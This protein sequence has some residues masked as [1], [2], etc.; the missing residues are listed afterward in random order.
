MPEELPEA[1]Q[2]ASAVVGKICNS[3]SC[4]NIPQS[5]SNFKIQIKGSNKGQLTN[6]CIKCMEQDAGRKR[7]SRE[8][9]KEERAQTLKT[10]W[11]DMRPDSFFETLKDSQE[12]DIQIQVS[13]DTSELIP[14][15]L[16]SKER[17]DGLS[18]MIND[19]MDLNWSPR[20]HHT[21]QAHTEYIY[22]WT[23]ANENKKQDGK[24][25]KQNEQKRDRRKMERGECGGSMR[26]IVVDGSPQMRVSVRHVHS[27]ASYEDIRLPEA[28][29]EF[30]RNNLTLTPAKLWQHIISTEGLK[31]LSQLVQE[32]WRLSDDPF[33]SAQQ[34]LRTEGEAAFAEEMSDVISLPGT[35]QLAFHIKDIVSKWA[36]FTQELA[37]D[38]TW[39]TNRQ[40]FELFAA[41]ADR[42]YGIGAP[43]AYLFIQTSKQAAPGSK[44]A[45]I[46]SWLESLKRLGI[47]PEF[48]LT[49][50]DQSEINA[51]KRVWPDAKHQ[52]CFWRAL[53]AVK[54]RLAKN[55]SMPAHYN[56]ESAHA[57]FNFID[58]LFILQAQQKPGVPKMDKPPEKPLL[59]IQ[60]IFNNC[61]RLLTQSKF[62]QCQAADVESEG[63]DD[64]TYWAQQEK[65]PDQDR[66]GLRSVRADIVEAH[67]DGD[68][69]SEEEEWEEEES[70]GSDL[71]DGD[72]VRC[73]INKIINETSSN[74]IED[75]D[76][77]EE[78]NGKSKDSQY[79]F[80]P[81][82]HRLPL[83]C[84][85]AKH[86]SLHP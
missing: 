77:P 49:D 9:E 81:S 30:I 40:N 57:V 61:P 85:F 84:L 35:R 59:H 28:W 5:L 69:D 19:V 66:P 12:S 24:Q 33:E 83:L 53:R 15:D 31:D 20:V 13:V 34:Y 42:P 11:P 44:E 56:G 73:L 50:K 39:N 58:P 52:L 78:S 38:S 79:I 23:A 47:Q 7:K 65:V 70:D 16:S 54:Q 48:V 86:H 18:L 6:R 36:P 37:L 17:A 1:P 51:V 55:K 72:D 68:F 32:K 67:E 64:D 82:P 25:R 46:A 10:D 29:K 45:V 8:A 75:Q 71:E 60:L 76:L 3:N 74:G 21:R 80:C 4:P 62:A 2:M 22:T 27:H 14:M 26:I 43:L 63:S 41:V